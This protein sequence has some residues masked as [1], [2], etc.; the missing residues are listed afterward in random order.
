MKI[1]LRP[2]VIPDFGIPE[3]L[4]AIPEATYDR[5]CADAYRRAACDWLVVYA[6]REHFANIVFL[7]G[8]E[9]RFEEALLL[10]GP[11]GARLLV[12]G[13]EGRGYAPVAR[14]PG[15]EVRLAQ[16]LSLMGQDRSKAPSIETVLRDCGL[17]AGQSIGIAGWKYMEP[18]E[19]PDARPG[20]FVPQWL[21]VL[22][23]KIAGKGPPIADATAVL[24]H[25]ETGLRS[26]VD[27]DQIA[28]SE[29][30]SSRASAA[31]WRVVTETRPG[32]T[33]FTAA[34][35]MG[36]A[37]EPLSC[38]VMLT[39]SDDSA[40]VIGLKS[41][42]ARKLKRGDGVTTAIGY[43]GGLSCR[44]GLLAEDDAAFL[45]VAK[46][47]FTG[48][49]AWYRAADIGVTGGALR[50]AMVA[51][52]AD[53]GLRSMLN[54][55]HL[56]SYDEWS[57]SPVRPGSTET[58]RSGMVFQVDVIPEPL[59]TGWALNCEDTV[60]FAD[61]ALRQEIKA[62]H[63]E[64]SARIGARRAFMRDVL[65]VDLPDSILPLSNI[66]LCLPPFWLAPDRLLAPSL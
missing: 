41:P 8:F 15:L 6:D 9:P 5:R 53:G 17:A 55:G 61:A 2:V 58:T 31:V 27:A 40:P 1:D 3:A 59:R 57:H 22:L 18:A 12:V 24:M 35:R 66:P 14:L 7:S 56:V 21:V 46:V 42:S 34:A 10:L 19:W 32:D 25:P 23:G 65:G 13:N 26:V 60:A 54:P 28:V 62:R 11:A 63:P 29:W 30:A 4:P 43:W 33:E 45:P 44:A 49:L 48:L 37:G 16:S 51:A 50:E 64:V 36:Y 47:Y 52:L 39:S 38:H 20:M